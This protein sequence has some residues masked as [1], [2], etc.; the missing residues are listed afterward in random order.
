MFEHLRIIAVCLILLLIVEKVESVT[1]PWGDF[2]GIDHMK[3]YKRKQVN[4]SLF[5]ATR[6]IILIAVSHIISISYELSLFN[7]IPSTSPTRRQ[8]HPIKFNH[9]T[10]P[11]DGADQAKHELFEFPNEYAYLNF[12]KEGATQLKELTLPSEEVDPVFLVGAD[13]YQTVT[14]YFGCDGDHLSTVGVRASVKTNPDFVQRFAGY[15]CGSQSPTRTQRF[16]GRKNE[17][18]CKKLCEKKNG[19]VAYEHHFRRVRQRG[20]IVRMNKCKL[21]SQY[22]DRGRRNRYSTCSIARKSCIEAPGA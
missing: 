10:C 5:M 6:L 15:R 4:G 1:V 11:L 2:C 16:R 17:K 9:A 22:P 12:D 8:C 3:T 13:D 21:Y 7:H 20:R 18:I 14:R 19:C